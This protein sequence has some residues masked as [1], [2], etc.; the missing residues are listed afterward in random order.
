MQ[1][2]ATRALVLVCVFD[3]KSEHSLPAATHS[4]S[5]AQHAGNYFFKV[6]YSFKK[7]FL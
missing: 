4:E 7:R 3:L 5:I 1:P 2:N 6:N